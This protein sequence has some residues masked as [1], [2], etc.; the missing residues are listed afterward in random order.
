MRK[1][2]WGVFVAMKQHRTVG[3]GLVTRHSWESH[4][5]FPSLLKVLA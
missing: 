5:D 2:V 4:G 3:E 1:G